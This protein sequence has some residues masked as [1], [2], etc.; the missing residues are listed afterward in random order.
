VLEGITLAVVI[1]VGLLV[2]SGFGWVGSQYWL[3]RNAK[4]Q[5]LL[6]AGE[7][8]KEKKLFLENELAKEQ[9]ENQKELLANAYPK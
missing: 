7:T 3:R 2:G 9:D 4:R 1:P 8:L 6:D 5:A